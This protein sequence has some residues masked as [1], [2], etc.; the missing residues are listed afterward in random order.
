[1]QTNQNIRLKNQEKIQ[2]RKRIKE[3]NDEEVLE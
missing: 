2:R 1:M 3:E